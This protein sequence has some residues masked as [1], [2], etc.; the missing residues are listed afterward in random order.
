M[1]EVRTENKDGRAIARFRE[2]PKGLK[3]ARKHAQE[4]RVRVPDAYIYIYSTIQAGK[5]GSGWKEIA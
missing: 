2:T 4:M 1:L 5:S 3:A